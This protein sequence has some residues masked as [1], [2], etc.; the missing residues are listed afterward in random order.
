MIHCFI[1]VNSGNCYFVYVPSSFLVSND[2]WEHGGEA[3]DHAPDDNLVNLVHHTLRLGIDLRLNL[4]LGLDAIVFL[5]RALCPSLS[6]SPM[7]R[8]LAS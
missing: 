8:T 5:T 6:S 1:S 7:A 4:E 3:A 2:M